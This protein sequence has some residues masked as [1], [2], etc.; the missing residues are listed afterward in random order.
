MSLTTQS[1]APWW[2]VYLPDAEIAAWAVLGGVALTQAWKLWRRDVTGRKPRNYATVLVAMAVTTLLA[3]LVP[4]LSGAGA[5]VALAGGL[6]IGPA[7]PLVWLVVRWLLR[8]YAP[9]LAGLVG[10]SRRRRPRAPGD[11]WTDEERREHTL[12]GETQELHGHDDITERDRD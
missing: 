2:A 5:G 9:D 4:W 10:E 11:V 7:S 6:K 3:T 1:D 12:F 8:R